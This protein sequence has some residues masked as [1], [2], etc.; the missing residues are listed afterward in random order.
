[1]A[2][3]SVQK[4]KK[5]DVIFERD[6][7]GYVVAL[8]PELPGCHTQARTLSEA[9]KMIKEAIEI[10]LEV[11]PVNGKASSSSRCMGIRQVAV[12]IPA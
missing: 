8:V 1:M 9:T 12:P 2:K 10:Y 7:S 6:E 4:V 5:F 3:K 11:A